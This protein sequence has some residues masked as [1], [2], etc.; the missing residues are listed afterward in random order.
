MGCVEMRSKAWTRGNDH[1]AWPG[2]VVFGVFKGIGDLLNAAPTIAEQLRYG[3]T[4][5]VLIFPKPE[6]RDLIAL[7]NLADLGG[8]LRIQEVAAKLA[9]LPSNW[10]ALR[11]L[12]PDFVW[13]SPHSARP[14]WKIPLLLWLL[15]RICWRRASLAGAE[16]EKFS[17]LFDLRV[18][19]DRRLPYARREWSAY[20]MAR[21]W[22]PI[23]AVPR[24]TLAREISPRQGEPPAFDLV[25]H[26]GASTENKRWPT[27][28]YAELFGLL[29]ENWRIALVGLPS[30]V[31][32]IKDSLP[33]G[34]VTAVSGTLREALQVMARA[35]V[36]LTMDSSS[37]HLVELLGVPKVILFGASDPQPAINPGAQ[38]VSLQ[39][40]ELSCQP[41]ESTRC[42]Y[43]TIYCMQLISPASVLDKIIEMH[44]R[45]MQPFETIAQRSQLDKSVKSEQG[46]EAK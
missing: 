2:L 18:P 30:E 26:P 29:P 7:L 45:S 1:S 4:V 16:S 35:R 25:I 46:C 21:G 33:A 3:S 12:N 37:A 17:R 11:A 34:R 36:A 9:R 24:V 6:L 15:R 5:V 42:R 39:A 23:R 27:S 19:I 10:S 22:I 32:A 41:C 14:S 44:K 8:E 31:K 20:S 38:A 40:S 28:Y 43:R 13:V